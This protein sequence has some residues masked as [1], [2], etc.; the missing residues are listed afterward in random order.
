MRVAKEFSRFAQA[1]SQHNII[2]TEVAQKL[3]ENLPKKRYKKIIDVGCGRGETYDNLS[4]NKIDFSH[5]TALDIA[6]GMLQLHPRDDRVV[7]VEGDFAQKELF[8]HLPYRDYDL[9]ISASALQWSSDL[10]V[11]LEGL[12]ILSKEG[13]FVIFTSGTFRSLHRCAGIDS[14]IYS[15]EYLKEKIDRYF[16]ATYESVEYKLHFESV[17]A[18][19]RYIKESGTSGGEKQLSYKQTKRLLEQYPLDYLE[20]EVLFVRTQTKV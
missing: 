14:P 15:K 20:F 17:Y 9:M 7:L 16:D 6:A 1:Y 2:Q 18:M 11:T 13:Y 8:A 19:L 3:L 4:K 5:L 12:S 10:D